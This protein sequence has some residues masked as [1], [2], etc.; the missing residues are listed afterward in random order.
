MKNSDL[1]EGKTYYIPVNVV[2][3]EIWNSRDVVTV[4]LDDGA[5]GTVSLYTEAL[6][7]VEEVSEESKLGK[8]SDGF[9]DGFYTGHYNDTYK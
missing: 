6:R 5:S 3:K 7:T 2:S 9:N 4:V 1:K 8:Y